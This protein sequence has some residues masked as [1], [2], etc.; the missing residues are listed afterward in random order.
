MRATTFEGFCD[1][2]ERVLGRMA[3]AQMSLKGSKCELLHEEL[4]VTR[5]RLR[6]HAPWSED[7]ATEA[8]EPHD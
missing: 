6:R 3:A 1:L 7:A 8:R 5:I 2:F 4:D